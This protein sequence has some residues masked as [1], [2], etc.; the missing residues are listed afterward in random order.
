MDGLSDEFFVPKKFP[1]ENWPS[2][3]RRF[4]RFM[5]ALALALPAAVAV[6]AVG[7]G[8]RAALAA[9]S[10]VC[11]PAICAPSAPLSVAEGDW[12]RAIDDAGRFLESE[13]AR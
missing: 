2:R 8:K 4:L 10:V 13:E 7:S 9:D 1:A 12:L 3:R 11:L 5:R 6:L